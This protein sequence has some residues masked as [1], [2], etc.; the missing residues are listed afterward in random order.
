MAFRHAVAA[1][2]NGVTVATADI[3][4]S[5]VTV[6]KL[7]GSITNTKLVNSEYVVP[8]LQYNVATPATGSTFA[9]VQLYEAAEIVEVCYSAKTNGTSGTTIVDVHAGPNVASAV[10]IFATARLSIGNGSTLKTAAPSGTKGSV[11][12]N[13]YI[14]IDIDQIA[15]GA[16]ANGCVTVWGKRSLTT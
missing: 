5:A 14:R 3:E 7:A 1:W 8:L 12:D 11:A 13:G 4:D 6:G 15:S 10:S 16:K 2:L 9:S